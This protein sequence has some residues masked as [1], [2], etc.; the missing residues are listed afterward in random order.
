MSHSARRDLDGNAGLFQRHAMFNSY[1][2]ES[3]QHHQAQNPGKTN[4]Q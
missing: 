4:L 2:A 1:G 3:V